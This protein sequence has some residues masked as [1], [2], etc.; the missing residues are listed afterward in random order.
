[1]QSSIPLPAPEQ[2]PASDRGKEVAAT[3]P[4]VSLLNEPAHYARRCYDLSAMK[5]TSLN[6]GGMSREYYRQQAAR[7]RGLAQDAT[8]DA[9][10]EHLADVAHQYE[11]LAE[12]AEAS[13]RNPE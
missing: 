8:T 11:K 9:V 12:D 6:T 1:M 5:I 2:F 7:L 4:M 10:R 3:K 13:N